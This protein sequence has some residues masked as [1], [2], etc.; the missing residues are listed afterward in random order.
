MR[1]KARRWVGGWV[2]GWV[3]CRERSQGKGGFAAFTRS[4]ST[5][6]GMVVRASRSL[7]GQSVCWAVCG[8]RSTAQLLT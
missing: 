3:E 2:D 4:S 7:A 8:L 1:G 5:W 6:E